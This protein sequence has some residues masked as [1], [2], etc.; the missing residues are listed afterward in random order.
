M[1]P[2]PYSSSTFPAR[3]WVRFLPLINLVVRR[4]LSSLIIAG[5]TALVVVLMA[6]QPISSA[7]E[8]NGERRAYL[9]WDDNWCHCPRAPATIVDLEV[10]DGRVIARSTD[11]LVPGTWPEV[12]GLA[13]VR[14][15]SGLASR[16]ARSRIRSCRKRE[17]FR[18]TRP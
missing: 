9:G 14:L 2:H 13:T 3:R 10:V 15:P 18:L 12:P 8:K 16:D 5:I 11:V 7:S 6:T 1:N 4:R 17:T